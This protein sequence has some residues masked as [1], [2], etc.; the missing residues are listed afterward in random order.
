MVA[1][2]QSFPVVIIFILPSITAQ[3][4]WSVLFTIAYMRQIVRR[5]QSVREWAG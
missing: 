3:N 4:M 5:L 2:Y 1:L